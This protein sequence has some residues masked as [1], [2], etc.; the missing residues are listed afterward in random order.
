MLLGAKSK[1][2]QPGQAFGAAAEYSP[3]QNVK[4]P[5]CSLTFPDHTNFPDFSLTLLT[6]GKPE[7]TSWHKAGDSL[8][9]CS[10]GS[11]L[12]ASRRTLA[13]DTC[14]AWD[15][16]GAKDICGAVR[17]VAYPQGA[18]CYLLNG[19]S[20]VIF[21]FFLIFY[22]F[23]IISKWLNKLKES[24]SRLSSFWW[25]RCCSEASFQ[26]QTGQTQTRRVFGTELAE[27]GHWALQRG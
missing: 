24:A 8:P 18:Q 4:F 12:R 10:L 27:Q 17:L 15:T 9:W 13:Q 16:C 22:S 23:S 14:G 1:G 25:S 6:C 3:W 2:S 21:C 11:R 20:E 5:D 7:F 19:K 26:R